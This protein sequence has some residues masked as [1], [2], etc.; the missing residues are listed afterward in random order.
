MYDIKS[1]C[2]VAASY[3][4]ANNHIFGYIVV[5]LKCMQNQTSWWSDR[6]VRHHIQSV[7]GCLDP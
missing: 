5:D 6:D 3:H 2:K 7:I 4:M 1:T